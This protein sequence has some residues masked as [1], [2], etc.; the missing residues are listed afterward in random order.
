MSDEIDAGA[1]QIETRLQ[2]RERLC[3]ELRRLEWA[4]ELHDAAIQEIASVS[5]LVQFQ[6]AQRVIEFG[7]EVHHVYFI[8]GGRLEGVLVDRLGRE[9]R[10]DVFWRGSVA[11][12]FSV[13]LP[14]QSQLRVEALEPTA[15]IRLTL[16]DLLRLTAGYPD[17][18]LRPA[19]SNNW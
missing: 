1:P 8:I 16:A 7:S 12:L 2:D 15:A 6:P 5:T 11:G 19:S 14:G 13:L 9:L 10:R 17:F 4:R 3:V 18:Q